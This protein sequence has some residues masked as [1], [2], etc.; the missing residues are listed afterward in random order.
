[1][2][3]LKVILCDL[4]Y[5]NEFTRNTTYVPL[6]IGYIASHAKTVFGGDIDLCLLDDP[7]V[8]LDRARDERPDLIAFSLYFWNFDLTRAVIRQLRGM[9][10]STPIL[11]GGGPSVD[12]DPTVQES[13][14]A[15]L[16]G[17]DALIPNEGELGFANLV[18]AL[19]SARGGQVFEEPIDGVVFRRDGTL[20]RGNPIGFGL[21]LATL[22]S[23]YLEGHLDPFVRSP[24]RPLLQTS[25][26]CPYTCA[27]CVSGKD[28]PKLRCFPMD[29]VREEIAYIGRHYHGLDHYTMFIVDENFGLFDRDAEVAG[30]VR[31]ASD[32]L[33]YPQS[34]F[35]YNDKR[36]TDK[37][38]AVLENLG[39]INS[40]GLTVAL[41]SENE[42]TLR[43]IGRTN[44][45]EEQ[46]QGAVE[47]AAERGIQASTEL[48][49][50]LPYET[51]Q[52][53]TTQLE[54]AVR[55]GFDSVLCHN[56]F[57]MDGI[58]LNRPDV[59]RKLGLETRFRLQGPHYGELGD[60]FTAEIEEVVTSSSTFSFD[61]FLAIRFLNFLFYTVYSLRFYR[62]FFNG[63]RGLGIT[64]V[65][66]FEAFLHPDPERTWP[67]PYLRFLSDLKAA[68]LAELHDTPEALRAAI[69]TEYRANDRRIAAPTRLN[70]LFGAR[71]IY[72]ERDWLADV[73]RQQV[74]GLGIG[75]E[76]S[77][78][79]RMLEELLA[80]CRLERIDLVDVAAPAPVVS[81][82]DIP[83]WQ[84]DKFRAPLGDYRLEHP[85]ELHFDVSP[86]TLRKIA[87]F[88]EEFR[89]CD[90]LA[91][92]YNAL[93][94]ISPRSALLFTLSAKLQQAGE[95]E[96]PGSE[97]AE[98]A[99]SRA[100][101]YSF[102]IAVTS[103]PRSRASSGRVGRRRSRAT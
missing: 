54:N 32:T 27:F 16:V 42:E 2:A 55:R 101:G 77:G 7:H 90:R 72:L 1:M 102:G 98:V 58:E 79:W 23:P 35:F 94:S 103:R 50:G 71:L 69:E 86:E 3:A 73:L 39:Q 24:Y 60:D 47:W 12:I 85:M 26:G 4:K 75:R 82:H 63:V 99:S 66:L 6:N 74:I 88:H 97:V 30:A 100:E 96:K 62:L 64:P 5:R 19:L 17:I 40:I 89:A 43:A 11:A 93:D 48:I 78:E 14:F 9:P 59:R 68:V 15:R 31:E 18:R 49:F 44:L 13:L 22:P 95:L 21:D 8:V 80:V 36:L 83:R 37:S 53:F 34:V 70:V 20:V 81:H 33:G 41:Q 25:R 84:D 51:R 52:S 91:Y 10:G 57:L 46:I 65:R 28:R 92:H 38:K 61:D 45:T 76:R 29:Q 87:A 67:Q 56:L